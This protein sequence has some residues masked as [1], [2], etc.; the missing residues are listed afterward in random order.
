MKQLYINNLRWNENIN[1]QRYHND[2]IYLYNLVGNNNYWEACR[3][4]YTKR[5]IIR[6]YFKAKNMFT[7]RIFYTHYIE[8]I[9]KKGSLA[10]RN[11]KQK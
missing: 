9:R 11:L 3:G 10:N 1:I 5:E 6:T 7:V 2:N 4:F 8:R